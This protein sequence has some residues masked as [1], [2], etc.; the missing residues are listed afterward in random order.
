[1]ARVSLP[2]RCLCQ[3]TG[4]RIT[5]RGSRSGTATGEPSGVLRERNRLRTS[6]GIVIWIDGIIWCVKRFHSY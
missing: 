1:M 3:R 4:E 2:N 6:K 5:T